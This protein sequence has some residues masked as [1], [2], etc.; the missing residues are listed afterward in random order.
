M[1]SKFQSVPQSPFYEDCCPKLPLHRNVG[2]ITAAQPSV[3]QGEHRSPVFA[4]AVGGWEPH[5]RGQ[6]SRCHPLHHVTVILSG[7]CVLQSLH[8]T[9]SLHLACPRGSIPQTT[10][11]G[12]LSWGEFWNGDLKGRRKHAHQEPDTGIFKYKSFPATC[13][14]SL[15]ELQGWCLSELPKLLGTE[16]LDRSE[17]NL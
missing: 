7:M 9:C 2:P 5:V 1:Q 10:N 4:G 14:A 16:H 13:Q 6:P 11:L 12:A 17:Q 15:T 3:V 8:S